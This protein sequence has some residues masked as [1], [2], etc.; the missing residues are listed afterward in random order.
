MTL[1]TPIVIF[2]SGRGSNMKSLVEA[3]READFPA[4]VR[5]VVSNDPD[6]GGL[7]WAQSQ[8]IATFALDHKPFGKDREV[9][10][11]ALDAEL[12]KHGI[13]FVCLAGYMRI[14][15]PF[16]VEKWSGRMINIHPSLL[17]KY[18]G[19]HTHERAIEAGDTEAGCTVHWVSPGV[20]EGEVI[21]QA[22]VPVLADDTPDAL[23]QRVLTQE[24]KLYPAALKL[25]LASEKK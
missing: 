9:H 3:A 10:E 8:G 11:R 12:E 19:L 7:E 5:L 6:A 16:I 2:I 25:A 22:R 14:L 15:T 1:K 4:E 21:L 20:D 13:E 18:R 23:S 17:P 24:H